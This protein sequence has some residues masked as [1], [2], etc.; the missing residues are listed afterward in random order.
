MRVTRTCSMDTHRILII[1]RHTHWPPCIM[2]VLYFMV[3][4][5]TILQGGVREWS[6][7]VGLRLLGK[8]QCLVHFRF[9]E[10]ICRILVTR[11]YTH[12]LHAESR[13]E[14]RDA[15]GRCQMHKVSHTVSKAAGEIGCFA[16]VCD[17]TTG[18]FTLGSL[19]F[20][21]PMV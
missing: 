6:G 16:C 21:F 2:E 5:V 15:A 18:R 10:D 19:L 8:H 13:C 4:S 14:M 1:F 9:H 3:Q 12:M 17:T 7:V 20:V 11:S